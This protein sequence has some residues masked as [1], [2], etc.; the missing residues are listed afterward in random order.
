MARYQII[1]L[2]LLILT[3]LTTA[4]NISSPRDGYWTLKDIG[5][6]NYSLNFFEELPES[7]NIFRTQIVANNSVN[8]DTLFIDLNSFP[9][10]KKE[11]NESINSLKHSFNQN[12]SE[13][14]KENGFEIP[15]NK[16]EVFEKSKK[17]SRSE[18]VNIILKNNLLNIEYL[19]NDSKNRYSIEKEVKTT[20][21]EIQVRF[22]RKTLGESGGTE[23]NQNWSRQ[24]NEGNY[25]LIVKVFSDG[26]EKES[27][28]KSLSVPS[29]F[30]YRK[31]SSSQKSLE[32]N[33]M[34]VEG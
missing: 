10:L 5:P 30:T 32:N 6:E 1:L 25:K 13:N 4:D 24:I 12:S 16:T 27:F 3:P 22:Y 23:I 20:E 19:F 17:E 15:E 26:I 31:E 9:N 11:L 29:N 18:T 7:K 34:I 14:L 21:D 28:Q 8:T 2:I 33:F